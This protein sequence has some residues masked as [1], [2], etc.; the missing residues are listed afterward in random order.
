MNKGRPKNWVR[1]KFRKPLIRRIEMRG[2]LLFLIGTDIGIFPYK[3]PY[4]IDL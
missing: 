2:D 3:L 1:D 4:L